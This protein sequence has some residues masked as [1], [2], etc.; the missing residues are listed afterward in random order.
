LKILEVEQISAYYGLALALDNASLYLDEG[1]FVAIIGSNGAG[2]STILKTIAG[3]ISPASGV[4]KWRGEEIQTKCLYD[5]ASLG[6]TYIP[7]DR[8]IFGS[9]TVKENLELGAYLH[10]DRKR[11]LLNRALDIFP[12][13][14]VLLD[15]Q[16]SSLSGGERQM[17]SMAMGLMTD[18]SLYLVDEP[19]LGLSPI[20]V[21]TLF[22][23]IVELN[24]RGATILLVEQ[25]AHLALRAAA[26]AYVMESHKIIMTGRGSELLG[27]EHIRDTY[28]GVVGI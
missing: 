17:L 27:N 18:P 28:L 11:E 26:R 7:E 24:E 2:K 19:S 23:V 1:E 16:A 15:R 20:V 14:S 12:P 4:I 6:I 10:Q 5:I 25:N 21:E 3:L 13:L 9:L 22:Q 8:S